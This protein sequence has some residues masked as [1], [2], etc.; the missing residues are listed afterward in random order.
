MEIYVFWN[1]QDCASC[2]QSTERKKKNTETKGKDFNLMETD[3][4][5][6]IRE[7]VLPCHKA[8]VSPSL[9]EDNLKE[10][11]L[12]FNSIKLFK[13]VVVGRC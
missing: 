5:L 3:I 4:F 2:P 10:W 9:L 7:V 12:H 6:K 1:E 11:S 13:Q 8:S